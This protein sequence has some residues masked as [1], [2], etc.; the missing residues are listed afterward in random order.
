MTC[1]HQRPENLVGHLRE[2]NR[3]PRAS[4][5]VFLFAR[6]R[7]TRNIYIGTYII[8]YVSTTLFILPA[9]C[10][11]SVRCCNIIITY[12]YRVVCVCVYVI[13]IYI[14]T[15]YT[16]YKYARAY[17]YIHIIDDG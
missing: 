10:R 8:Y 15:L 3:R 7:L 2:S 4:K 16:Y 13:Y 9:C 11:F 17:I 12:V 14:G 1:L 5:R 6:P